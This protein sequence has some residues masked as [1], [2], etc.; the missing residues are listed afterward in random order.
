MGAPTILLRPITTALF[1]ATWTPAPQRVRR[2]QKRGHCAAWYTLL[3]SLGQFKYGPGAFR[4]L[5]FFVVCGRELQL[6]GRQG[7]RKDH[8]N[9]V[10]LL[11]KAAEMKCGISAEV[12]KQSL[13]MCV[14]PTL[15]E[16]Y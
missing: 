2:E 6:G 13:A 10:L 1:P 9:L 16:D 8:F 12:V 3:W 11:S 7:G 4:I 5:F 15:I 14:I